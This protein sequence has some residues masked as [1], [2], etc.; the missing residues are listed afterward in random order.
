M[1]TSGKLKDEVIKKT[2]VSDYFAFRRL[3]EAHADFWDKVNGAEFV[4]GYS[5]K[6]LEP[7]SL[8]LH[9]MDLLTEEE[10]RTWLEDFEKIN[11]A[12]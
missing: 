2:G 5:E 11:K 12:G 1:A 3:S 7:G 4:R 9:D 8:A 6:Y 10:Y